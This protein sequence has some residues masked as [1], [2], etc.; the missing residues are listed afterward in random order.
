M[1]GI[2]INQTGGPEELVYTEMPLPEPGSDEV[3]MKIDAAG[4][5]FVD[6]YVRKGQYPQAPPF[7]PGLEAAGIVDS[8]GSGVSNFTTG[9]R[10]AYAMQ[11]GSYAEYTVVPAWKLAKLPDG[12]D[13][14]SGAAVMLQGMTAH[15]L[16]ASTYALKPGDTALVHAAA[17]GVGRLLVQVAKIKGAR[18]FAVV[19]TEEKALLARQAGADE[20]FI[21]GTVDFREECRRLVPDGI[22]VVYDSVGFDT[23]ERSLDCLKPRGMMALY[24]QAS[25]P[26]PPQDLQILNN[27]GSLFLTRPSLMHYAQTREE[28]AERTADLFRW[29]KTGKLE[30][31]IDQEFPLADAAEAHRYLEARKTKGKVLLI[32]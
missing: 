31:K 3:R 21:V 30:I 14:K 17:G 19:S 10:V 28:I 26:V 8:V 32:P 24:G 12:I 5:N 18:V 27:K 13:T 1:K 15:Y 20:I 22:D 16:A 6:I 23:F 29:I 7:V 2:Q 25:G 4:V 9:D 11:L